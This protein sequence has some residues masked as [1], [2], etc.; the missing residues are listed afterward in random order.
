MDG[1]G[2]LCAL[3]WSAGKPS[4]KD[5]YCRMR[6]SVKGLGS[7]TKKMGREIAQKVIQSNDGQLHMYV[8][9]YVSVK[10]EI[11]QVASE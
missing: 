10:A 7:S 6:K 5:M 11:L 9:M 3:L 4:H 2:W 1:R 8:H